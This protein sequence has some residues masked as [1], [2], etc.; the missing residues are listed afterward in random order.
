MKRSKNT[1]L[2]LLPFLL[3][4]LSIG[5]FTMLIQATRNA[6][7][8]VKSI[9]TS[10]TDDQIYGDRVVNRFSKTQFSTTELASLWVVLN[11]S[12]IV[13]ATY[14]PTNLSSIQTSD[15]NVILV[16]AELTDNIESLLSAAKKENFNIKPVSGY[17]DYNEQK[18]LYA[19]NPYKTA[20]K[21]GFSEHQLGIAIDVSTGDNENIWLANHAH[22]YGFI[23]RYPK[24]KESITGMAYEPWHLRYVGVELATE[25]KNSNKTLEEYF[26]N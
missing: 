22:K 23:I 10:S 20:A 24:G 1:L 21:P 15:G 26:Q 11:E 13:P 2:L 6:N 25:I 19:S 17:R 8:S 14:T 12:N 4:T 16:R 7:K 3:L 5:I 18:K 9:Q